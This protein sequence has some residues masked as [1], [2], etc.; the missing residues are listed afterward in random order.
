MSQKFNHYIYF[1]DYNNVV[2][3]GFELKHILLITYLYLSIYVLLR[4][5]IAIPFPFPRPIPHIPVWTPWLREGGGE[6]DGPA[7]SRDYIAS[8]SQQDDL[9]SGK[10]GCH[11]QFSRLVYAVI[12][13][14]LADL[15]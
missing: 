10:E 1:S 4:G 7:E 12:I 13:R 8:L 2:T 3:L 15:R 6:C 11:I 9:S 14:R 5:T